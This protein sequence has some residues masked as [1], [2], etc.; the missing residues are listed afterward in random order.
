MQGNQAEWDQLYGTNKTTVQILGVDVLLDGKSIQ[1]PPPNS[2]ILEV[3]ESILGINSTVLGALPEVNTT[4]L[5]TNLDANKTI[6]QANIDSKSPITILPQF[7]CKALLEEGLGLQLDNSSGLYLIDSTNHQRLLKKHLTFRFNITTQ[8]TFNWNSSY[9][10]SINFDF[11]YQ[12]MLLKVNLPQN[13]E[14]SYYIPIKCSDQS[15]DYVLGRAFMQ[16]AYLI[17]GE[18][19]YYLAKA[20]LDPSFKPNPVALGTGEKIIVSPIPKESGEVSKKLVVGIVVASIVGGILTFLGML[21]L[22]RSKR[23]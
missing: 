14:S 8:K 17:V 5:D 9:V 16:K 22:L 23:K 19:N 1:H 18:K 13:S 21:W 6:L 10:T 11:T 7:F 15:D 20:T 2:T 12:R 3:F 4:I